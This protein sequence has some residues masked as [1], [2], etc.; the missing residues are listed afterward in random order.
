MNR[1]LTTKEEQCLGMM[2]LRGKEIK[3]TMSDFES[4]Y[5]RSPNSQELADLLGISTKELARRLDQKT[6]AKAMLVEFNL[7]SVVPIAKSLALFSK[8]QGLDLSDLLVAGRD[9]LESAAERYDPRRAKFITHAYLWVKQSVQR[10]AHT[11][12][13]VSYTQLVLNFCISLIFSVWFF[14]VRLLSFRG[15]WSSLLS[16]RIVMPSKGICLVV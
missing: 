10:Y 3:D 6:R 16:G 8:C 9:G 7:C 15:L 1:L 11:N 14:F 12:P 5:G 4:A 2:V 13:V